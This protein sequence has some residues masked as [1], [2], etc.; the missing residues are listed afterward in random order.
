MKKINYIIAVKSP[1]LDMPFITA[2]KSVAIPL[3]TAFKILSVKSSTI[4]VSQI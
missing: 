3:L 1:A 4:V 2:V